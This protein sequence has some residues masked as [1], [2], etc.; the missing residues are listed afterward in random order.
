MDRLRGAE[1][2]QY[3]VDTLDEYFKSGKELFGAVGINEGNFE[4]VPF[5]D[6]VPNMDFKRRVP[7]KQRWEHLIPVV[8]LM[9]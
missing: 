4:L 2:A 6:L 7:K 5:A 9:R 1:F 8:D 3:A